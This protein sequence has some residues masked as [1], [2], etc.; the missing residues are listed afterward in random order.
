MGEH[1]IIHNIFVTEEK[2]NCITLQQTYA[3][4]L[5]AALGSLQACLCVFS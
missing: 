5:L 3:H 4:T 2:K 1:W